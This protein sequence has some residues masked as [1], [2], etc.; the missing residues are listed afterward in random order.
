MEARA[1]FRPAVNQFFALTA[2][3]LFLANQVKKTG[4][5]MVEMKVAASMPPQTPVPME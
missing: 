2:F 3:F 1:F 4:T 5:K